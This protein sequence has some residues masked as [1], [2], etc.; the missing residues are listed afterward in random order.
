VA[1]VAEHHSYS[2]SFIM[3]PR[4]SVKLTFYSSVLR[5][6]QELLASYT[7]KSGTAHVA[8]ALRLALSINVCMMCICSFEAALSDYYDES[9]C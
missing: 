2:T 7:L 5:H 3:Q 1:F 8:N 6:I 9:A 4:S